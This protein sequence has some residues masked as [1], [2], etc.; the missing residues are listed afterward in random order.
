[1][2]ICI[3][4][5]NHLGYKQ[6]DPILS[7]DTFATF[8][9]ILS[10][11]A[12]ADILIQCGDLFHHNT[13][14]KQVLHRTISLLQKYCLGAKEVAIS[15]PSLNINSEVMNIALPIVLI[16]GNH[17]DP[18]GAR[19]TSAIDVLH[20]TGFV[21][22]IGKV[23]NET[24]LEPVIVHKG[25]IK[26]AIYGIGY[27][28]DKRLYDMLANGYIEFRRVSDDHFC[29]FMMHQNLYRGHCILDVLPGWFDLILC[30]HEHE[31]IIKNENPTVIQCGSTVRTS[32]C[33]GEMGD[34]YMYEVELGDSVKI[35]RMKLNS[36]RD[37]IM[38]S[39]K[40]E[41]D[42]KSVLDDMLNGYSGEKDGRLPLLRLRMYNPPTINLHVLAQAYSDRI[43][44]VKDMFLVH[45][46]KKDAE[47][48]SGKSTGSD[49]ITILRSSLKLQALPENLMLH[50]LR[51]YVDSSNKDV[52][53]D[54]IANTIRRCTDRIAG[55]IGDEVVRMVNIIK[56]QVN[57]EYSDQ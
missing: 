25:D 19:P 12:P 56:E 9:E 6:H 44:N 8:E 35:R 22:Y 26:V 37:L 21:N 1:M 14:S 7:D 20:A 29:I 41:S 11:A 28:P 43:A 57:M 4:S 17:D 13:P 24:V 50:S 51:Q 47:R 18:S 23:E 10:R 38:K 2:K 15:S 36:V 3:T 48:E 52:F 27:L 54:M 46:T 45:R 55:G 40:N 53:E 49:I 42:V 16:H 30:G 5:D 32:M 39:V 31:P 34:K 33:E